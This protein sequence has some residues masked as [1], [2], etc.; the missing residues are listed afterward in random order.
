MNTITSTLLRTCKYH[1]IHLDDADPALTYDP[2]DEQVVDQLQRRDR[3][4]SVLIVDQRVEVEQEEEGE[5]RAAVDDE[6]HEGCVDDVS[7]AGTRSEQVADG[8]QRP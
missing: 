1:F 4:F 3:V 6:L 2:E 7:D 8:E 5:I